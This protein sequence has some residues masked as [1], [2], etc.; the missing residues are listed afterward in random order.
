LG[1][2]KLAGCDPETKI[3][4]MLRKIADMQERS[5]NEGQMPPLLKCLKENLE[6]LLVCLQERCVPSTGTEGSGRMNSPFEDCRF[7]QDVHDATVLK[8]SE[9]EILQMTKA[10]EAVP[11]AIVLTDLNGNI[12]YVNASLLK[13]SGFRD[14]SEAKGRSVFVES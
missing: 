11:T 6:D 3:E 2:E 8:N 1:E 7:L 13:N 10:V 12:E 14:V 5:G 4:Q 9:V